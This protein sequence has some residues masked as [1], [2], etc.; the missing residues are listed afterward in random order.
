MG[1]F[2]EMILGPFFELFFVDRDDGIWREFSFMFSLLVSD[3]FSEADEY[4]LGCK[5]GYTS[6]CPNLR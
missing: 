6:G 5:L 3:S 1:S 4:S 2:F